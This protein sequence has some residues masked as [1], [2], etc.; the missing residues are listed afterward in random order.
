MVLTDEHIE[1]LRAALLPMK[2][3]SIT[4]HVG[5]TSPHLF[6]DVLNKLKI[7]KEPEGQHGR[8]VES[9]VS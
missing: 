4:I 7:D 5:E 3:G 1:T 2:Y 6:I 8:P 9:K